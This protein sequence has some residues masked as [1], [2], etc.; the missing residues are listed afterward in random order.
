MKIKDQYYLGLDRE[1]VIEKFE[2][3]L[4]FVAEMMVNLKSSKGIVKVPSEVYFSANP[5][6]SK[7]H[8]D[9]MIIFYN[10]DQLMVTGKDE[11]EMKDSWTSG[12]VHCLTCDTVLISLN[13][14][15]FHGCGCDND[16]FVDGGSDYIRYGAKDLNKTKLVKVDMKTKTLVQESA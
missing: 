2:G 3:N 11:E 14:H 13:R 1:K 10:D 4:S 7:N 12:G 9:Y 5:D 15:N 6:R 8:K 16:T